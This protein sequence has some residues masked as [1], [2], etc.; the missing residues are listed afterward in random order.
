MGRNL[1]DFYGKFDGVSTDLTRA[2]SQG[3]NG[4]AVLTHAGKSLYA[5]PDNGNA[6]VGRK[7]T[8]NRD[9]KKQGTRLAEVAVGNKKPAK[10][11]S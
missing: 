8:R 1:K 2:A 5:T 11:D 3:P 10:K 9:V 6:S 7:V 4:G